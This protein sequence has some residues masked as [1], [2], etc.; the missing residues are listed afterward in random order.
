MV[1]LIVHNNYLTILPLTVLVLFSVQLSFLMIPQYVEGQ[2]EEKK[3]LDDNCITFDETE[4]LIKISCE[5]ATFADVYNTIQNTSILSSESSLYDDAKVWLLNAGI[6][7]DKNSMLEM[8]SNDVNWL[9]IVPGADTPNAISVS[10][11][12]YVDS[13]KITSWNPNTNDYV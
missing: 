6:E 13:V 9:K 1:T 12:L 2:E 4:N 7:V 8:T 5:Y 11:S 10:G 3:L